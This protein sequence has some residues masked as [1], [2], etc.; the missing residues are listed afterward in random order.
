MGD[1]KARSP[2]SDLLEVEGARTLD[3]WTRLIAGSPAGWRPSQTTRSIQ[4]CSH[5]IAKVNHLQ[6]KKKDS[7]RRTEQTEESENCT[8]SEDLVTTC[9]E[10]NYTNKDI[11]LTL[12]RRR[13]FEEFA[14]LKSFPAA[15]FLD[16]TSGGSQRW[17]AFREFLRERYL[18][19]VH[20]RMETAFFGLADQRAAVM[21]TAGDGGASSPRTAWFGEF[22]EMAR[23]VWLLH[24]LFCAFDGA[25]SVFQARPGSRFSEVYMESVSGDDDEATSPAAGHLA[26]GFTVV[27]GFKVGQTVLQCRVYLSRPDRRP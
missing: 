26:V 17:G 1:P 3:A 10:T 4:Q 24:C 25:A 5:A 11:G 15:T 12:D 21:A 14:E 16:A 20:E 27:P 18:S 2:G 13:F 9:I 6:K 7:A 8:G 22:A 23:R 19:L